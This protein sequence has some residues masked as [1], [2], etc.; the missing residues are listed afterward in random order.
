MKTTTAIST[1][2]LLLLPFTSALDGKCTKP[3]NTCY[4]DF[5]SG[6]YRQKYNPPCGAVCLDPLSVPI[7]FL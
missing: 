6:K 2:T 5:G 1:L 7:G 3:A 4:I